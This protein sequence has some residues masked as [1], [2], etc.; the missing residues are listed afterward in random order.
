MPSNS[1]DLLLNTARMNFSTVRW[2]FSLTVEKTFEATNSDMT[3]PGLLP[4]HLTEAGTRPPKQ[5]FM[6]EAR[7]RLLQEMYTIYEVVN[8]PVWPNDQG[9]SLMWSLPILVQPIHGEEI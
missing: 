4:G 3:G 2:L 1:Y 9:L 8:P 7:G 5:S 6:H